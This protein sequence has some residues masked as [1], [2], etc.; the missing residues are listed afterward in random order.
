MTRLAASLILMSTALLAPAADPPVEIVG[1]RGAS[2]DAPENTV[3][4]FKLSWAQKADGSELD[5]YL[6]KD[7]K[8]VVIHD[9]DTKRTAGTGMAVPGATLDELRALDVGRWKGERFA[10]E[11]IPTLDEMLAT[12]PTGKR[13]FVEVKCGPE[14][15]AELDR[16]LRASKLEPN[17]TPVIAFSADVIAAVKKARPDV[18]AYWLV[19]LNPKG[20]KPRMAEELIAKA[21]EIHAD[22]LDL[23]AS[24]VLDDAFARKV[25]AAGLK[26]YVWTVNDPIVA[27]RLVGIG[28]DGITTDRPGW[29][30]EQL[31]K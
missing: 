20:A 17:Q 21:K 1:H 16:V 23:S 3:A 28:V 11:K 4:S 24:D 10:G 6:T 18:P 30:R 22:G 26:L 13:V 29:L 27:K 25:K 15:V 2:H 19:T 12:A 5:I 14:V 31:A 7:G 8:A 9:K